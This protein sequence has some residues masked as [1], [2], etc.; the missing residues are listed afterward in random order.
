MALRRNYSAGYRTDR[1]YVYPDYT[2]F[3]IP[4]GGVDPFHS[5]FESPKK[6]ENAFIKQ[7]LV[8]EDQKYHDKNE[9]FLTFCKP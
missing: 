5:H 2:V 3:E 4:R 6:I 8:F 1:Y 9:V 7:G